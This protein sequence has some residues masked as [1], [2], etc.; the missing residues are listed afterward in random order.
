M[1]TMYLTQCKVDQALDNK[2]QDLNVS[3][4]WEDCM[5]FKHSDKIA[6]LKGSFAFLIIMDS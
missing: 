4:I 6:A 2:E 3:M 1:W 5:V